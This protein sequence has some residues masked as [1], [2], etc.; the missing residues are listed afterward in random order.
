MPTA[1]VNGTRISYTDTGGDGIPVVLLHAFPLHAGMWQPQL[2][3]LGDRFR[4]IAPD[5]KGF[6]GSDAPD[7]AAGYSMDGYADDV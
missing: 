7:D 5:L 4:V 1:T 3:A 6:G 2:D